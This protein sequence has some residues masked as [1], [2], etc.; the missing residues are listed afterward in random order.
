M[1]KTI[2]LL[3]LSV[4]IIQCSKSDTSSVP[5][6]ENHNNNILAKELLF[7][8]VDGP[9][10]M[11]EL[12]VPEISRSTVLVFP[13]EMS[14]STDFRLLTAN[15]E[16]QCGDH[17]CSGYLKYKILDKETNEILA[18]DLRVSRPYRLIRNKSYL[19]L[20]DLSAIE[21]AGQ[22]YHLNFAVWKG[23]GQQVHAVTSCEEAAGT[24][25]LFSTKGIKLR[26]S[27]SPDSAYFEKGSACGHT[28]DCEFNFLQ[29][30][31][32]AKDLSANGIHYDMTNAAEVDDLSKAVT[33]QT[34]VNDIGIQDGSLKL[35]CL[36]YT[37]GR[38]DTAE[39]F[40]TRRLHSCK[41][42]ASEEK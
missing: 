6:G 22:N 24:S 26:I 20:V 12:D 35:L 31:K 14:E 1:N 33:Y 7:S 2:V 23:N 37:A 42:I 8:A 29:Q 28:L 36:R 13:F 4:F 3:F 18:S 17:Q 5:P 15:F 11:N 40:E 41:T 21:T 27:G 34:Q 16:Y 30:Y 38:F 39:I 25:F 10:Q 32:V 19:F 9:V